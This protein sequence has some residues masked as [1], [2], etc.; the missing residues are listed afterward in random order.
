MVEGA[1]TGWTNEVAVSEDEGALSDIDEHLLGEDESEDE[2]EV[3]GDDV[4]AE[5]GALT[6]MDEDSGWMDESEGKLEEKKSEEKKIGQE[7]K[8]EKGSFI[9]PPRFVLKR[10]G[11]YQRRN[12]MTNLKKA[13]R[14]FYNNFFIDNP[15]PLDNVSPE[16]L[17]QMKQMQMIAQANVVEQMDCLLKN[18]TE[19]VQTINNGVERSRVKPNM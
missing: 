16:S 2:P 1:Q 19:V 5:E 17:T 11:K 4:P 13:M 3:A 18:Y 6:D 15:L 14:K 10:R 8:Q 9:I 12:S 7:D